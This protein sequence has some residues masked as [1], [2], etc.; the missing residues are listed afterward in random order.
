[1]LW[2]G[3]EE[4][5]TKII[6]VCHALIGEK[7]SHVVFSVSEKSIQTKVVDIIYYYTVNDQS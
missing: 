7:K 4:T 2:I 6:I 3:V 5:W 1:M